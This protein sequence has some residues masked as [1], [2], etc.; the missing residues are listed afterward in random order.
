MRLWLFGKFENFPA[1]DADSTISKSHSSQNRAH[2]T[3][4]R[5]SFE[6]A[7][8]MVFKTTFEVF[9]RVGPDDSL[10]RFTERSVGLVADR[11][12]NVYELFVTLL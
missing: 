11:P 5:A 12:S 6:W 2:S 9:T 1:C 4:L 7:T 8:L 3:S 10:K